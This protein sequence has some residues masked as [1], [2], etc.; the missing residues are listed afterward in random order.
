MVEQ[1]KLKSSSL[2]RF[3]ITKLV[4][5]LTVLGTPQSESDESESDESESDG[6][7]K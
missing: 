2:R 1:D 3:V 7:T 5:V 4:N 6:L